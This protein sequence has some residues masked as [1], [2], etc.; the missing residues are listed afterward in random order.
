DLSVLLQLLKELGRSHSQIA[1]DDAVLEAIV[2]R[3][4]ILRRNLRRRQ[5]LFAAEDEILAG[6]GDDRR[7]F[8]RLQGEADLFDRRVADVMPDGRN[9]AA[10][11]GAVRIL[12]MI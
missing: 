5:V 9:Q 7:D 3:L 10:G 4:T 1:V 2:G 12:R 11:R 8:P 6:D